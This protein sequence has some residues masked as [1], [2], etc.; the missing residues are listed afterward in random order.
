M[1]DRVNELA[2]DAR[3]SLNSVGKDRAGPGVQGMTRREREILEHVVVGRT[4]AEIAAALF[5]S[6]KTVSSHISNMLRKT[7]T[8]NRRALAELARRAR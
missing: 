1:L 6:E 3:I 8:A 7:G 4:Y 5:I 2:R